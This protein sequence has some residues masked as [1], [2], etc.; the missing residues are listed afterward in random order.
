[1]HKPLNHADLKGFWYAD[2]PDMPL[3]NKSDTK[4]SWIGMIIKIQ[5]LVTNSKRKYLALQ[6]A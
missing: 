2:I 3:C 4:N 6:V 5:S 1:V